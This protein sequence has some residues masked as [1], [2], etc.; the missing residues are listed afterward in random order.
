M[1]KA[2]GIVKDLIGFGQDRPKSSNLWLP[3]DVIICHEKIGTPKTICGQKVFFG[4][5][6]SEKF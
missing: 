3:S 6:G 5:G 4:G 2:D 1:Y